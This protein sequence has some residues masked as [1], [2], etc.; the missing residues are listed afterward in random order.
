[1]DPRRSKSRGVDP[2]RRPFVTTADGG[3][4]V[5]ADLR[6]AVSLE[7][8]GRFEPVFDA[9]ARPRPAA[10]LLGI[11]TVAGWD[12]AALFDKRTGALASSTGRPRP[13]GLAVD[14]V[15]FRAYAAASGDDSIAVL[16]LLEVESGSA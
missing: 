4:V 13:T 15:R 8:P 6:S 9:R 7:T 3:T 11:A 10:G 12:G 5:A 2:A 16:D 1:M 14:P